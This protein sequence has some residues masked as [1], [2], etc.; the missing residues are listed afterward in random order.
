MILVDDDS[1]AVHM[2]NPTAQIIWS[3]FDG[4][5]TIAEI[6]RDLCEV[7]A[8]DLAAVTREVTD[9]ARRLGEHGLLERVSRTIGGSASLATGDGD[10]LQVDQQRGAVRQPRFAGPPPS[11]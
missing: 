1:G 11:T 7:F 3:C 8:A 4:S 6:A 9:V 5:G 2:L 10:P